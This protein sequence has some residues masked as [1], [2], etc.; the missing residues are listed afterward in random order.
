LLGKVWIASFVFTRCTGPC[1][2][3]TGTMARLQ[4]EL[5][6]EPDVRLVTFTVDP[7]HDEPAELLKYAEHVRADP[8]RWLFLTGP[9]DEMHRLV[10][11]TFMLHVA[12]NPN[13]KKAG[14]EFEHSARLAVVDRRGQIRGYFDG[15]QDERS[16]DPA[17]EFDAELRDLKGKVAQLLREPSN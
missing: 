16:P 10:R 4:S 5:A 3:V 17:K 15:I 7:K 2:H 1:P 12:R 6:G 13:P 8:E 9:E 11:E 14:D